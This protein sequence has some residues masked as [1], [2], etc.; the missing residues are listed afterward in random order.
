MKNKMKKSRYAPVYSALIGMSL[1]VLSGCSTS[2]PPPP[3][4]PSPPET[5][6]QLF[7]RK[8][9]EKFTPYGYNCSFYQNRTFTVADFVTGIEG[10]FTADDSASCVAAE[11]QNIEA[12]L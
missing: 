8:T 12:H 2:S 3:P 9:N 7:T 1:W 10:T 5:R 11:K 4:V 6:T